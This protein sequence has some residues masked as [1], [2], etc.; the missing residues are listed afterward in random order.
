MEDASSPESAE[1]SPPNVRMVDRKKSSAKNIKTF[2]T[3]KG[4]LGAL[5][6]DL[7]GCRERRGRCI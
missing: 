7:D 5:D 3:V 1:C 6:L 2:L 4:V